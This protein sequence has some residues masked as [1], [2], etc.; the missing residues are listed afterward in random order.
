MGVRKPTTAKDRQLHQAFGRKECALAPTIGGVGRA[1]EL[2]EQANASR[3]GGS[4]LA[5]KLPQP[6][7]GPPHRPSGRFDTRSLEQQEPTDGLQAEISKPV[8]AP[9]QQRTI[10]RESL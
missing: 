5:W 9:R 2:R 3:E 4:V 10:Y 1:E 7:D 6:T 8:V